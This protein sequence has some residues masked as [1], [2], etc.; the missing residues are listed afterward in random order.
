MASLKSLATD[1]FDFIIKVCLALP[2]H[3]ISKELARRDAQRGSNSLRWFTPEEAAVAEALARTIVPSDEETPGMDEVCVLDAPAI[4]ALDK[5][6]SASS[7]GQLLY[8]RGLLSFDLWAREKHG[9]SFVD[10]RKEDQIALLAA[11][12]QLYE[13]WN[14]SLSLIRKV[15]R[16]FRVIAAARNGSY[17]ASLLYPALRG[18]CL[19]VFYTSRVCW[20]WLEYDGPPMEKGYQSLTTPREP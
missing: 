2:P 16:R 7:Q 13:G 10:L 3:R 6:V 17:F 12:Q 19:R 18:D 15:W 5:Q 11:A 20:T 1:C 8:S 14:E 4:V 9:C